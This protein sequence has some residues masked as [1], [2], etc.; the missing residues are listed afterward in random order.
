MWRR[1]VSNPEVIDAAGR[2]WDVSSQKVLDCEGVGSG[3]ET[4]PP[5]EGLVVSGAGELEGGWSQVVEEEGGSRGRR[6][7]V[8]YSGRMVG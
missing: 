2:G 8:F 6:I 7:S 4:S 3:D 5:R 1:D